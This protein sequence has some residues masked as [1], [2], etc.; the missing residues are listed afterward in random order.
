MRVLCLIDLRDISM[1]LS[2][3]GAHKRRWAMAKDNWDALAPAGLTNQLMTLALSPP[4][5]GGHVNH[6]KRIDKRVCLT[7]DDGPNRPCTEDLLD[8]LGELGVPA[9]FFCVGWNVQQYPDIAARAAREGHDVGNHSMAHSR[10]QGL[11]PLGG[12]HIDAAER[13]IAD[14]IGKVPRLY[15]PPWGWLSPFERVRLIARGY[16][17]V[18]WDVYT[19]DWKMPETDGKLMARTAL[20][21][22]IGGS[23]ILFHDGRPLTTTWTKT[24]TVRAVRA[25]VPMVRDKG[26]EFSTVSDL[27]S[28][29]AYAETSAPAL[30]ALA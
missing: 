16:T 11:M 23:I 25:L 24:E 14:A 9:T 22:V 18:G 21:Q 30:K 4:F 27:L 12:D 29:P 19:R 7:F 15:R 3:A 2:F 17:V 8:A 26:L 20:P 13:V 6:G 1:P 28:I 5:G 10:K